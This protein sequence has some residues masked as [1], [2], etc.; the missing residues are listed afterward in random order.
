MIWFSVFSSATFGW[1]CAR[2]LHRGLVV[3]SRGTDSG[4]RF[5]VMVH[6]STRV[7]LPLGCPLKQEQSPGYF[8][9][10]A[11]LTASGRGQEVQRAMAPRLRL[12]S[13]CAQRTFALVVKN[14][15]ALDS[16]TTS[17]NRPTLYATTA[18]H[19]HTHTHTHTHQAKKTRKPRLGLTRHQM[20]QL[21]SVVL[22]YFI[23]CMLTLRHRQA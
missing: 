17:T 18:A 6:I 8:N 16:C 20:R 13:G 19:T 10:G 3:P 11:H 12:R 4:S 23:G 15:C 7:F 22:F 2:P 5:A 9:A 1:L 21:C 14:A